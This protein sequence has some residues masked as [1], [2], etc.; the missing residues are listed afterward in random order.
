MGRV[1]SSAV[2]CWQGLALVVWLHLDD[3]LDR[4]AEVAAAGEARG[5]VEAVLVAADDDHVADV[6]TVAAHGAG[7]HPEAR[8]ARARG[9]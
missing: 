9:R 1:S 3:R 4:V 5:E 2:T 6:V 8:G 7:E